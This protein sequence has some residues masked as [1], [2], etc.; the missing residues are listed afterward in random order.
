MFTLFAVCVSCATIQAA[1][2]PQWRGPF[3]NGSTDETALPDQWTQTDN[4]AWRVEL[5]G[6]S[7]ATPIIWQ[8][9]VFISSTDKA[10]DALLAMCF[11]RRTGQ[12]LWKH[13]VAKGIQ[14]DTRSNYA[15]PS[16]ATDGN[17]VVF[18]YGN[19]DLLTCD[20]DG[21]QLW[22]KNVGPFAFM[23]TF[24]A[25]PVL[26]DGKL[27]VQILQRNVA[28]NG[29]G[30]RGP[31]ESYLLALDP[32]TGTELFRQV[33]PCEA[34]AESMEAYT[35][36]IP[37][38]AG[39][40]RQLI[41]AGGDDLTAHDAQTGEELWRWGTWNPSR[42]GHWRL[43]PSP[44]VGDGV[45]L[46]CAPKSDPVYAIR[47]STESHGVRGDREAIAWVS[48]DRAISSD[49]PTP[50]FYG[51]DFFVLND[52][53]RNLSRVEPR[54][55]QIRW[56]IQTPGRSKYEA[57][58]LAADGKIYLINFDGEVAIVDAANGN[59]LRV[60]PMEPK[61]ETEDNVRSSVAAAYG[62]LFI[63]TNTRLYCIGR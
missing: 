57:S 45:V 58:P 28:V 27:Y 1:D 30:N 40:R 56:S 60:I 35:T 54:T 41:I 3:F 50:A 32:A 48:Q 7:A 24:G 47:S 8:D 17:L 18:F 38:E 23:W 16:A 53:G 2:W 13:T 20:M 55:G 33:R 11:D 51:G 19:G 4:I 46:V 44:V 37:F 36:P 49:V 14:R 52:L 22:K 42:I 29:Q 39:G 10:N 9:R 59:L 43:V 25:S 6:A 12:L 63:R 26:Y 5:P 15:S 61:L 34:R 62:Q 31:N 21:K